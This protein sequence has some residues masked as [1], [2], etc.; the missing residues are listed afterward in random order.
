MC[1]YSCTTMIIQRRHVFRF[2]AVLATVVVAICLW[3][4]SLHGLSKAG[5]RIRYWHDQMKMH[6]LGEAGN[7]TGES[8]TLALNV[9]A[10]RYSLPH[11]ATVLGKPF[12]MDQSIVNIVRNVLA[13][14][15]FKRKPVKLDSV[16]TFP[17]I[18]PVT[19]A[20]SNHFGEHKRNIQ[21]FLTNFPGLKL[22]F[23]DLGLAASE[24]KQLTEH[25]AIEYRK[26]E[27][28]RY[29]A[30]VKNLQNYCW[31]L[32]IIQHLLAESDGVMWF[33]SSIR[34]ES[35]MTYVKERM[36][37][38]NSGFLYYVHTTGHSIVSATH[39]RMLEY[40]P[41]ERAGAIADMPQGGAVIVLNTAEVQSNIM[42]WICMCVLNVDCISPPGS[43]L[44]CGFNFPREKFG[45]CH[46]YDQSLLS[47]LVSNTYGN[48]RL[49]YTM[50]DE[51]LLA[52]VQRG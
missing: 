22:I 13:N 26:F 40:F 37:R 34:F 6:L 9:N 28:T 51:K 32:L 29:P 45:G 23:Y 19:A 27:F 5:S 49:R 52:T 1:A 42:K 3:H 25:A 48:E 14:E 35:N 31:K 15:T 33:D 2:M 8:S 38:Y 46:R 50:N 11:N 43:T 20:S 18:V 12:I 16:E 7:T 10:S 24:I 41:M 30:H 47:I 21:S 39:P 44:F 17:E 4:I 36:V